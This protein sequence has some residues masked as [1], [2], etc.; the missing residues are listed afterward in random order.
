[1]FSSGGSL[2]ARH[3]TY[4]VPYLITRGDLQYKYTK[5]QV[6]STLTYH[7]QHRDTKDTG[8]RCGLPPIPLQEQHCLCILPCAQQEKILCY[9][10]IFWE[11]LRT[12]AQMGVGGGSSLLLGCCLGF[13]GYLV[14][15]SANW[16]CERRGKGKVERGAQS[17]IFR[18]PLQ[19]TE[20]SMGQCLLWCPLGN[21]VLR[22]S[23]LWD[24]TPLK[25]ETPCKALLGQVVLHVFS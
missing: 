2:C 8:G 13:S 10:K 16:K 18:G 14:Q 22:V 12:W 5:W 23:A 17:G 6:L 9:S 24:G 3:F 20:S 7:E 21:P 11:G 1:M 25:A 4:T 15:G 19:G